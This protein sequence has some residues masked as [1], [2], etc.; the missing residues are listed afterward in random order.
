[1]LNG[2]ALA[3]DGEGWGWDQE[4]RIAR[5][6]AAEDPERRHSVVIACR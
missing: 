5:V 6:R 2:E 4:S 3:E 1:M